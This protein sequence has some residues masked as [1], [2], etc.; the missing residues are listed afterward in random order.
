[1]QL[2]QIRKGETRT[3]EYKSLNPMG[4]VP[5]LVEGDFVLPE[6]A[7]IMKY[8]ARKVSCDDHWCVPRT[9]VKSLAHVFTKFCR[10]LNVRF[11]NVRHSLGSSHPYGPRYPVDAKNRARVDAAVDYYH[12]V[13]RQGAAGLSW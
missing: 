8:F 6:S 12:S 10:L 2:I 13:I 11:T 1:M 5:L 9:F 3:E 4:K 7:A